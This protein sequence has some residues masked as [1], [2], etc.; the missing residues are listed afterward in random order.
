MP[1]AEVLC[2]LLFHPGIPVSRGTLA[3]AG[4][5]PPV[6]RRMVF[7]FW[8]LKRLSALMPEVLAR[9]LAAWRCGLPSRTHL[10]SARPRGRL[11][12]PR[13]GHVCGP[14][15]PGSPTSSPASHCLPA[16]DRGDGQRGQVVLG[17]RRHGSIWRQSAGPEPHL[18]R[19]RGL[20]QVN[21]HGWPWIA[22]PYS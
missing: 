15:C 8:Q 19:R 16:G 7:G 18:C 11:P 1:S 17:V 22:F 14:G 21:T 3:F 2:T 20:H 13:Q 4:E 6:C 5:V 12:L 10:P 9:T